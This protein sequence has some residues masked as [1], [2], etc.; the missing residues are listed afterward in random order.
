MRRKV[1]YLDCLPEWLPKL[2]KLVEDSPVALTFDK[3]VALVAVVGK[4][5]VGVLFTTFDGTIFS[6]CVVV[7]PPYQRRGVGTFLI[8]EGLRLF[9]ET[10]LSSGAALELKVVNLTLCGL[11]RRLGLVELFRDGDNVYMGDSQ[12]LRDHSYVIGSWC[13]F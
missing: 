5:L 11:L 4:S 2:E 10:K 13:H 3:R 12:S 1:E 8:K 6:F 9:R 7:A